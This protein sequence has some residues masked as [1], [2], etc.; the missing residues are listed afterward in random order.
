M[1]SINFVNKILEVD[2]STGETSIFE[3]SEEDIKKFVGGKGLAY[4]LLYERIKP[5]VD[6][7]GPENII[8]FMTGPLTGT[9]APLSGRFSAVSK[10]PLTGLFGSSNCG[11]PFGVALK[12]AGYLGL[13]LK[14]KADRLVTLEITHEGL[15]IKDAENLRGLPT[16][17]TQR[18]L[19]LSKQ[20]GDLVIGP[21]GENL[22]SYACIRS[23]ERFLGRLGFGAVLGSK[24]VKAIVARGGFYKIVPEDLKKMEKLKKKILEKLKK[25][26]FSQLYHRYGTNTNILYSKNAGILPIRNFQTLEAGEEV[27]R[28]SGP[29]IEE[30]FKVK[31]KPCAMCSLVCGHQMEIDGTYYHVPEYETNALFGSNCGIFD[32]KEIAEINHLCN[33]LGLDTISAA[34]TASFVMEAVEKGLLNYDL[35][36]GDAQG[37]KKLIHDVAFR[38]GFGEEVARGSRYLAEKYGGKTFAI[39]VKGLEIAAYDPRN[40]WG[41]GLSYAVANRGGCHLSAPQFPM[42]A[43]FRFLNP[44]TTKSKAH[45]V[46]FLENLFNTINSIVTC[47]FT[48]F[49]YVLE[50]PI[51]KYTPKF[52]LRFFMTHFPNLALRFINISLYQELFEASSGI[53]LSRKEFIE[54]GERIHLLERYMNVREGLKAE[55]DTLPERFLKELKPIPL[56]KML[57]DY[58]KLRKYGRDGKPDMERLR[59]LGLEVS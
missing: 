1:E 34:V 49:S 46:V 56:E 35:R 36:F 4:K 5:H 42:E 45:Y 54:A 8:I 28:I 41:H 2:L 18:A 43:Y 57:S 15:T 38:R 6:P 47:V 24:N 12:S 26:E 25:N 16:S 39:Q 3:V 58:Y 7:L 53:R 33:E 29:Y 9:G 40:S 32:I 19:N 20:D 10:S 17:D 27:Y 21:A 44:H 59:R 37:L 23:G 30:H 14:G 52:L 51:I 55:D 11:G 13:I 22:V 50:D 48:T 31:P